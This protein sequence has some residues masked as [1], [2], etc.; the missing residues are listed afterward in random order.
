VKDYSLKDRARFY[1]ETFPKYPP[2]RADDRWIDGIWVLG[3]DYRGSGYYGSY[4][5]NYLRRIMSMFPDAQNILHLFSGSLPPGNYTRL[6]INQKLNPDIC[7]DAERLSSFIEVGK[8]DLIIAD[9]PYSSE[10]AEHYGTPFISRN[11]VLKECALVMPCGG[12]LIWLDQ[13]MP[14]FS[15]RSLSWVGAIGLIRSTNHRFR[16]CSWFKKVDI[17]LL[18]STKIPYK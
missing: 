1:T 5:P 7:G 18:K 11:K 17:T 8:Y 10:D 14:M 13:V 12:Y 4:P 9:P 2:L 15:K 3:Q 16:V 6:D